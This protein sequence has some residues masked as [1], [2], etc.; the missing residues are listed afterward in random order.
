MTKKA[1]FGISIL[2]MACN[3]SQK[4]DYPVPNDLITKDQLIPVIID[5][6]VL[7]S[8]YHRLYNRPDAYKSAVD[9]ASYFVFEKYG[10]TK[11]QFKRSYTYYAY[12]VNEMFLI[13]E[14]ALD[15]INLKV[16]QTGEIQ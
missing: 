10:T 4:E 2:L 6:Q 3:S 12:D 1:L 8:H 5:L 13:Y 7:E 16:S 11:D 9:S 14:A 15:S